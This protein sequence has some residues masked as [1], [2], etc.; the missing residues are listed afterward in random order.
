MTETQEPSFPKNCRISTFFAEASLVKAFQSLERGA[1]LPIPVERSFLKLPG[2]PPLKD[3]RFCSLKMSLES[4][5][6][7]EAGS[8]RPSSLSWMSWGTMSRGRCLTAQIILSPKIGKE[9]FL[10]DFLE[11]D[12]PDRYWLSETQTQEICNMEVLKALKRAEQT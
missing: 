11:T 1:P 5:R 10:S 2:L 4:C 9:C 6:L 12:V 7:T 8:L 3:L